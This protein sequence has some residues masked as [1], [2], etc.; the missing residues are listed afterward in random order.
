LQPLT[1]ALFA[2]AVALAATP[3]IRLAALRTRMVD[4]P[5]PRS[6]HARVTPRGGGLAL[7]AAVL[8]A[9]L[10][11]PAAVAR[12]DR[13]AWLAAFAALALV[14]LADDRFSLPASWRLGLQA[15][16]A[17]GF[18]AL[19]GGFDRLPLP[20]PLDVPLSAGGG[21]LA[22]LW[23]V[24]VVN[25]YNFLDGID[26]LAVLQG[27]VTA[28]GIVLA[29]WDPV[30]S[31]FAAALAGGCAGF[32][33]FNWSPARIFLG[34]TGSL[35]LGFGLAA[36]PLLAP[37]PQ[38][39]RAVY[40]VA[41]SLWLFLADATFTL[42]RRFARGARWDEAHREHLYQRL[43]LSGWSHGAVALALG[44]GALALTGV[45]LLGWREGSA[46]EMLAGLVALG[47]FAVQWGVVRAREGQPAARS[48]AA[49]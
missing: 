2:F 25:F 28:T 26:G 23:I 3:A 11:Y 43:V 19:A 46:R 42:L 49:A 14:G 44:A 16:A 10:L 18:V 24:A 38:R 7:L 39:S 9:V 17:A 21:P 29:A 41:V 45:A 35:A 30:A 36:L 31:L 37:P 4:V 32:L 48:G 13:V 40:F 8:A 5:G 12:A 6:S 33:L 47:L 20:A 15:A 27:T 1:T 22:V 34:D